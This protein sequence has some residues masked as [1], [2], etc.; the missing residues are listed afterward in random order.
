[1]AYFTVDIVYFCSGSTTTQCSEQPFRG[2]CLGL[3]ILYQFFR[4]TI[5]DARDVVKDTED[6]IKTLP[7][8]LR[9]KNTICLMG[10]LGTCVDATLTRGI[11]MNGA[12]GIYIDKSLLAE[13]ILRVG[14]T[15]LFYSKVLEHHHENVIAWSTD[16]FIGLT[17]VIWAQQS[18]GGR[19]DG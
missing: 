6:R 1:M 14:M 16:S 2:E 18:L 4:K 17:P 10:I 5:Y 19:D 8:R 15:M 7:I 11:S 9:R 12:W 13:A 3:A